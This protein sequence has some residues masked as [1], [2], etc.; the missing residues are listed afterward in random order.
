MSVV[1]E[2]VSILERTHVT[3]EDLKVLSCVE[4]FLLNLGINVECEEVGYI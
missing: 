1:L 4:R 3:A 2:V